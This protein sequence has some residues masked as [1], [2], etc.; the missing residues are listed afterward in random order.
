MSLSQ[1]AC[2]RPRI[3]ARLFARDACSSL[4]L[5]S[6]R[7]NLVRFSIETQLSSDCNFYLDDYIVHVLRVA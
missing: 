2:E 3:I 5:I 7:L 1:R 4:V 6:D